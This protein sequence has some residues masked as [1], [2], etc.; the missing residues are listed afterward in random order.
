MT[1]EKIPTRAAMAKTRLARIGALTGAV[2]ICDRQGVLLDDVLD[3]KIHEPCV[4]GVRHDLW[5]VTQDTFDLGDAATGR[6]FGVDHT[7]IGYARRLRSRGS[8]A[9]ARLSKVRFA[10]TRRRVAS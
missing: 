3:T 1:P 9:L 4:V 2:Q 6:V 5:L 10:K 7:S 8:P